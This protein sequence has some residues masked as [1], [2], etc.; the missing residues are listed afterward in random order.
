[1]GRFSSSTT[2][3]RPRT[4]GSIANLPRPVSPLHRTRRQP[5]L[6][7]VHPEGNADGGGHPH[8]ISSPTVTHDMH[9]MGIRRSPDVRPAVPGPGRPEH[10]P[11]TDRRGRRRSGHGH[12]IRTGGGGKEGHSSIQRPVRSVDPGP[13]VHAVSR[14]TANPD[15]DRK[16]LGSPTRWSTRPAPIGRPLGPQDIHDWNFPVPY[17][18][19]TWRLSRHR[20]VRRRSRCLPRSSRWPSIKTRWLE[21][22]YGVHK[23]WVE[24]DE[25]PYAFVISADQ[26]DPF[27]TYELL[28][29]L[30]VGEIEIHRARIDFHGRAAPS[31]PAGSWVIDL[32]QPYGAFAKTMLEGTGVSLTSGTTQGGPPIPPYD[33]TAH[34]LGLLM[35]VD[36]DRVDDPLQIADLE[37]LEDDVPPRL[38]TAAPRRTSTGPTP[39]A[40]TSNAGYKA[41]VTKLQRGRGIPVYPSRLRPSSSRSGQSFAPR[42]VDRPSERATADAAFWSSVAEHT[43]SRGLGDWTGPQRSGRLSRS[44]HSTRVGLWR[45]ANNMPGGWMM[46]LFEQYESRPPGHLVT[47]LRRRPGPVCMT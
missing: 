29:I 32:A 19:S 42:G 4:R 22:F 23:D 36:V 35:G 11:A 15:R 16:R 45:A 38:T 33:V 37:L 1:M 3:T 39:S 2:G 10:S 12:V 7:H 28:E 44:S 21:N 24:R 25:A 47:R 20:R 40:P 31:Y 43:G 9:Q 46:W 6:V 8:R 27:E 26:P 30:D 14:S 17:D 34:T 18:S 13:P 41:A 5:R